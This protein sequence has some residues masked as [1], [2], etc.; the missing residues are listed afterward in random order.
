MSVDFT[1]D[2][3]SILRTECY[4]SL[5]LLAHAQLEELDIGSTCGGHGNCGGDRLKISENSRDLLSPFT[6]AEREHLT[7]QELKEGLRLACQ[8]FP[9]AEHAELEVEILTR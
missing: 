6:E 3:N 8:A 7:P 1:K 9:R 2:G 4:K 5:N